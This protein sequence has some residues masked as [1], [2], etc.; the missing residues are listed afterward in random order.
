M[1]KQI[2]SAFSV[3]VGLSLVLTGSGFAQAADHTLGTWKLNLAKS[4]YSP[5][6][7][8]RSNTA[9]Y[10]AW[11]GGIKGTRDGVDAGG[12]STRS[13]FAARFDGKDYPYKGSAAWETISLKRVDDFTY[14]ATLRGKGKAMM[15]SRSVISKDGKTRTLTQTGT[16]AKGRPVSNVA[17]SDRQ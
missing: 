9:V 8:P 12:K 16:D 7:A 10:E 14:E 4:T 5:G 3:M 17:V 1:S 15:M 2:R 6:P 11:E 13:E